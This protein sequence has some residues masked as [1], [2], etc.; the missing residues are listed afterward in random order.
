MEIRIGE[1]IAIYRKAKGYT[2]EQMGELVG[3][4]GQAVSKWENGG[5]PDT[6][7]LPV[8]SKVL[9]VSTDA[10]FGIE[11]KISEYTQAEILDVLFKFCLQQN[12]ELNIFEFMFETIWTLQGA[13]FG[14]ESRPLLSEVIEKNS[15]NPQV[16]SQI[17]NDNGTTYLSLIKDFPF[18]CAVRDTPEISKKILSEKKFEK[19]FSLLG[20]AD[21]LKAVIFTQTSTE[22]SQYTAEMM[23]KKIGISLEKFLE[24]EPLLVE[25]GLLKKDTL[26]INDGIIQVYH[27]WSNPEIRPLLIMAYQFINARQCYFNF[28][29]NRTKPYFEYE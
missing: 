14:N 22:S 4:S 12:S 13:Y 23:A 6:Y 18:F 10:L 1:K 8:I 15:G 24:I 7:L 16:T 2:Q 28:T 27:K 20:S 17:I 26:T 5:V 21:G 11:K 3:V 25:Y 19:F 29:C 9:E